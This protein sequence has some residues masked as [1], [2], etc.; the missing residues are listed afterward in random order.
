MLT[1]MAAPAIGRVSFLDTGG[2][3]ELLTL[4]AQRKLQEADVIVHDRSVGRGILELARRDASRIAADSLD[5][6][7]ISAIMVREA[8]A[9]K[10]VVRLSGGQAL[11]DEQVATGSEGIAIEVIPAADSRSQ[12]RILN[13][14]V[15]EDFRRAVLKVAS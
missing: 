5:F 15:R 12:A 10:H 9:G 7:G 6:T 14:P 11:V 4:K 2:D 1:D 3:A 13:F 8:K